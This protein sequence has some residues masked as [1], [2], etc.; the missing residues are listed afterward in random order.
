MTDTLPATAGIPSA[1]A[2]TRHWAPFLALET[3]TLLSAVGNGITL[4]ALPWLVLDVT[5]R[6]T[7]AGLVS[8]VAAVPLLLAALFSGTV[9][10]RLGRR[11]TAIASDLLSALAVAAIPVVA[12]VSRLGLAWL[13]LLAALVALFPPSGATARA[14]VLPEAG[15]AAGL[16]LER[17]NAVHEAVFGVAFLVAPAVGGVL[18]AL[19]GAQATLWVPA[20]GYAT[21]ALAML[22]LR[23]EGAGRGQHAH[24]HEPAGWWTETR[25]GLRFVWRDPALRA[26]AIVYTAVIGVWLPIEGVVLPVLFRDQGEPARLGLVL[27]GMSGG[28]VVGALLYGWRGHRVPRRTAVLIALVGTSLPV[29]G[30]ALQP[31]IGAM[32]VLAFAS[33]LLYGPVNPI[34]NVVMVERSPSRLR[35]R[36]VGVLTSLAYAAG[37]VG[38]LAT[39]PLVDRLGV[40]T[41]F[42]LLAVALLAV[43]VAAFKL[44]GLRHLGPVRVRTTHSPSSP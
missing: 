14:A 35:G 37:P 4:V 30:M 7:A 32:V 29:L 24:G 42:V 34:A 12:V 9:V 1:P 36:V 16:P 23:V 26:I 18:I 40:E 20:V 15:R 25:E 3:A 43:C 27:M 22:L 5:G 33:G 17:A 31:P 28:A 19:I 38:L 21:A 44:D 10:D 6:A 41:T 13:L 2:A 8:G 11:P 39:G